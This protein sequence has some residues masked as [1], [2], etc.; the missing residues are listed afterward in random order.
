MRHK[1]LGRLFL[2]LLIVD[3]SGYLCDI[4]GRA[5]KTKD[6]CS[7]HR[8]CHGD[9]KLTCSQCGAKF[10]QRNVLHQ[11][12]KL[13]HGNLKDFACQHCGKSFATKQNYDN[14]CRIH[15]GEAPYACSICKVRFKRVH[16]LKK[17]LSTLNHI[18][19]TAQVQAKG[20]KIPPDLDPALVLGHD[21]V[22]ELAK[23]ALCD[24]CPKNS[25][26][27]VTKF[28]SRYH[29]H[30]HIKS[31]GH[32]ERIASLSQ[33]GRLI[34]THLLPPNLLDNEIQIDPNAAQIFYL[35]TVN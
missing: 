33:S 17:H 32:I 6:L 11:H 27:K 19:K 4:C 9:R 23:Q 31:R 28:K 25:E 12:K 26:E 15:S 10:K 13:K 16:H 30:K 14:H 35:E 8:L 1:V 24:I 7:S 22:G 34:S 21:E 3:F 18:D 2:S 5:F 20:G 29:F